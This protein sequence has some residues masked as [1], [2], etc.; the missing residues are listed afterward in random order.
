MSW[1]D[2]VARLLRYFRKR[3]EELESITLSLLGATPEPSYIAHSDISSRVRQLVDG[4]IEPI[5]SVYDEGETLLIAVSLPGASRDSISVKV[6]PDHIE[7]EADISEET[8]RRALGSL[9]WSRFVRRYRG[10]YPLPVPVDPSTAETSL[11]GDI[12]L[13]RVK[14]L[15][16]TVEPGQT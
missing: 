2:D 9:Y 4:V 11:R 15:K 8:V 7:V 14:K 13:I 12:L 6:Y 1:D 5:I 3:M 16:R 10:S